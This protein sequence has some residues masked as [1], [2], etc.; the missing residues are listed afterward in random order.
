MAKRAMCYGMSNLCMGTTASSTRALTLP[1][2]FE[3]HHAARLCIALGDAFEASLFC[4]CVSADGSSAHG[5]RAGM[6]PF[7]AWAA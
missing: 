7:G 4:K 5:C 6:A 3:A 1:L 2:R